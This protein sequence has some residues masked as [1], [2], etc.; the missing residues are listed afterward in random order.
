MLMYANPPQ[1]EHLSFSLLQSGGCGIPESAAGRPGSE[2]PDDESGGTGGDV[3]GGVSTHPHPDHR[4]AD[5]NPSGTAGPWWDCATG[6][7]EQQ[8]PSR[9]T[10]VSI[11]VVCSYIEAKI[12]SGD[13]VG[14]M[15]SN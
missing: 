6:N 11:N 1:T 7:G 4:G 13:K 12:S 5:P 10:I 14:E 15:S 9:S 2:R 3:A 8:S